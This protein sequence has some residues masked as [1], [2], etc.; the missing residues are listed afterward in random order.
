M[1]YTYWRYF[2]DYEKEEKWLNSLSAKGLA[3][4]NVSLLR[5]T[6]EECEQAEYEYR[7]ELLNN[8]PGNIESK[9]YIRFLEESHIEHISSTFRWIYLRKNKKYGSFNL[10][11]DNK[12]RID[13]IKRYIK[14]L[15]P[16]IIL[17]L[18]CGIK[19]LNDSLK[20]NISS[21]IYLGS[22]NII[23]SIS[24]TYFAVKRILVMKRLKKENIIHE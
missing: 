5:Y 4:V 19:I 16:L 10:F 17:N 18:F 9:I 24:L 14:L 6:F 1:K 12:S 23:L 20:F 3:L 8:L 13:H 11:S 21:I 15:L 2:I 7:L 22:I